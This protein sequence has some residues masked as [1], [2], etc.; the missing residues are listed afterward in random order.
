VR[1]II[2]VSRYRVPGKAYC[3][4]EALEV[5]IT[6][7]F[8]TIPARVTQS[9]IC[10]VVTTRQGQS[11]L[12]IQLQGIGEE[13]ADSFSAGTHVSGSVSNEA[14]RAEAC[15]AASYRIESCEFHE[16]IESRA[17]IDI[18]HTGHE[19]VAAT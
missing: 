15:S 6:V 19:Q 9:Y 13:P 18:A 8:R 2:G 12:I 3:R 10:I 11:D 4:I 17:T 1:S 16:G 7:E 14:A 5:V